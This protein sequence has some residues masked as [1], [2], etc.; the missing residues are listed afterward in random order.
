M[1]FS[2]KVFDVDDIPIPIPKNPTR[3]MDQ[4]RAFI[5]SKRL[6]YKTEKVYCFWILRYIRFHDRQHPNNLTVD[7][8]NQFL[9]SL[10]LQENVSV[11]TQKTA[12]NALAFLYNQF[13]S[14]PLEGVEFTPSSKQRHI[15]TVFSHQEA[16]SIINELSGIYKLIVSLMYGSGLRVM[17]SVR[18]RVQD[19]DFSNGCLIVRE[20]KGNYWR[21]TL[22]PSSLIDGLQNQVNFVLAQHQKDL[23]DGCGSVYLPFAL[24]RK[25]PN[26]ST[27]SGWQYLF[28]APH[29]SID[30]RSNIKRRHHLG[31][32][33]V[34]RAVKAAI[35]RVGILKKAGC[36]TFR[37]SFAT[38]L[39]RNGTDIRAIQEMLGH[40]D[41]S[42]TQ[43]YTHV[44]GLHER[45]VTSPLDFSNSNSYQ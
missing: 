9:S 10:V 37:H 1:K 14:K 12:L 38:N 44:V 24:E 18:L 34:Q 15:P 8:V 20:A 43:I 25:Y 13:L 40:R 6:S 16:M 45:G 29:Y 31:E 7:H 3:L 2:N 21:R 17:E 27:S 5:R 41:I 26:A 39:L 32:Q 28:P 33:S 36:H 11:N 4:L 19:V 42:T 30:P 23:A 35:K 22:L